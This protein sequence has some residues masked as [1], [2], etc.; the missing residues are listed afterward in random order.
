M[1]P[2]AKLAPTDQSQ[3]HI[4]KCCLVG[5]VSS[6]TTAESTDY[7][8]LLSDSLILQK[9]MGWGA[10]CSQSETCPPSPTKVFTGN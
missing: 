5:T 10:F 9:Q 8:V 2:C 3:T 4:A 1:S 7:S 6:H